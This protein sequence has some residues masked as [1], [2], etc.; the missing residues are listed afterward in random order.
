MSLL[1]FIAVT[2]LFT[3]CK[4]STPSEPS[5]G[6]FKDYETSG[7]IPD[8]VP[9][10]GSWRLD[11][12]PEHSGSN[13]KDCPS[14]VKVFETVKEPLSGEDPLKNTP[15]LAMRKLKNDGTYQE[16]AFERS[17]FVNIGGRDSCESESIAPSKKITVCHKS[18]ILDDDASHSL[19]IIHR[20]SIS[21]KIG[22]VLHFIPAGS[23]KAEQKVRV[24]GGNLYYEYLIDGAKFTTCHFSRING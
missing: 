10:T 6:D 15:V 14:A 24:I 13:A 9:M 12:R 18:W 5:T 2:C 22:F 16:R 17:D 19:S 11:A 21:E 7:T 4:T 8:L 20:V 1:K 23:S 3:A